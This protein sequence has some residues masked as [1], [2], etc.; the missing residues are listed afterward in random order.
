[1]KGKNNIEMDIADAIMER[2]VGFNI[3]SRH[4]CLY[5]P[6]LGKLY[7]LERLNDSLCVNKDM[8]K[9]NPYLESLRLCRDKKDVLCRIVAYHTLK[10]KSEIFDEKKVASRVALFERELDDNEMARLFILTMSWDNANVYI[11]HLGLN[12]EQSIRRKIAKLKENSGSISFGGFST[13]G[14]LIDSA[15]QRYGWSMDYVVW[16]ISYVNLQMLMADAITSVHLSK[17]EMKK[18]H[19]SP[20]RTFISGDDPE[21]LEKIKNMFS[22]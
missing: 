11:R 5:P 6:T 22:D 14:T 2:P 9:L 16:G 15:C 19:I 8:F 10:R 13:Y 4:F 18:L 20:D 21:N 7:L 17:E 12:R 3:G 1:M